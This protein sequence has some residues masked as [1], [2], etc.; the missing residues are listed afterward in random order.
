MKCIKCKKE[1]T[2]APFCC[3][4]G[5][6]QDI[7]HAPKQRGNGQGSVFQQRNKRWIAV[8]TLG[9][10]MDADGKKHRVTVSKSGFKTKREALEA[11]VT[12]TGQRPKA[13]TF[14]Q[15]YKAWLP[16]HKAGKSTIS[17]YKAAY[18]YFE[19]ILILPFAEITVDDLQEC[20]DDCPK[21]IKTKKNMKTLS[22]LLY[23]YAI[24]RR[25]A[26]MDMGHFVTVRDDGDSLGKGGLPVED[27]RKLEA[28]VGK[29]PGADYIVAQCY[30]GFRPSELLELDAAKYNRAERA[31][32]GGAKTEAG[33][34]RTVTVSP[35]IQPIVDRLMEGKTS[36][37]VFCAP[38]G[39]KMNI[40]AYRD[41][42]Y[43]VLDACGIDNPVTVEGDRERH[44][45]TPH[46]CRHTFATL[47]KRVPGDA[48]DKL[49]LIGHT[50][51]EML[52]HYQ[53]VNFDDLRKITDA[54]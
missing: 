45:Y 3:L 10:K 30:L 6:K 19:P 20:V 42:F 37:A 14:E 18:K 50:S 12:L 33:K 1:V 40:K 44:K 32:V 25:L 47:M 52:R 13:L 9:Y 4:C 46:S 2:D 53:D 41:L 16:T 22:T 27:L 15:V 36:G 11:L 7:G 54:L 5:Q 39:G 29:V 34:N 23:K 31:F 49:A 48:K 24:P 43:S 26:E 38:D 35:K 28:A 17:T 8:K 21:G 51:E